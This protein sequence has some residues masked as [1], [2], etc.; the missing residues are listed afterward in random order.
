MPDTTEH[1]IVAIS[2]ESLRWLLSA[3][4]LVLEMPVVPDKGNPV[5]RVIA[6][7]ELTKALDEA[8]RAL[9]RLD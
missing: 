6:D 1:P 7:R 4:R 5:A 3:A 8:G 9:E 2:A